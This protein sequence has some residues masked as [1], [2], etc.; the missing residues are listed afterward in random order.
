[1]AEAAMHS[2]NCSS[3]AIWGSLAQVHFDM[4][5]GKPGIE[6]ATPIPR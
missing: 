1:M 5:L 2:A 4:Q 6:A 3:G